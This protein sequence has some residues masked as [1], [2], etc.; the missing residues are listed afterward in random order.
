M[1]KVALE[2]NVEDMQ[3]FDKFME[4]GLIQRLQHVLDSDFAKI[5]Y[6]EAVKI[7]ETS[8]HKFDYPVKW[9]NDLQSEHERYLTENHFKKPVV[10]TDYPKEI[11]AFYMRDNDDNKTVAAMDILVP[12][13][14]EIVGGAQREERADV[15][16]KKMKEKN[17]DMDIY[18]WYVD[19]RKYGTVPHAGFGVGFERLLQFITGIENI[20]DVIAFPRSPGNAQF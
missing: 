3:F 16:I 5:T 17:L 8:K 9:G 19:L 14:G 18:K 4:K 1:V 12:K 7:L 11:K 13:I 15:L 20:R 6:T 10:V 2:E